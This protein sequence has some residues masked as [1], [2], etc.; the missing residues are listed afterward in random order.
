MAPQHRSF[1]SLRRRSLSLSVKGPPATC[2]PFFE[3]IGAL[4]LY[5]LMMNA[6]DAN[7]MNVVFTV[8]MGVCTLL[9]LLCHEEYRRQEM[10]IE[11]QPMA[12]TVA[13]ESNVA[14]NLHNFQVALGTSPRDPFP[15][16]G[17]G[18][19]KAPLIGGGGTAGGNTTT[20]ATMAS[21]S[22]KRAETTLSKKQQHPST[23]RLET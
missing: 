3:N 5:V 13:T 14:A 22:A 16:W 10:E 8:G 2:S 18:G 9:V 17:G 21:R 23:D 6:F 19:E 4:L 12:A 1:M 7:A 20:A 11:T 15:A